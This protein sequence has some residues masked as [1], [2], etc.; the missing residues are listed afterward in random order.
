M[1]YRVL[2]LSTCD[3]RLKWKL[4]PTS[5]P[6]QEEEIMDH[7]AHGFSKEMLVSEA[8][9]RIPGTLIRMQ[10]LHCACLL[11]ACRNWDPNVWELPHK[12]PATSL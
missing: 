3:Y 2:V 11:Q 4:S 10:C 1:L 9:K 5:S 6:L 7:I 8:M 12:K